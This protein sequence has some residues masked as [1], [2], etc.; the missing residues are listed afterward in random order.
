[1]C[2]IYNERGETVRHILS[3]FSM[4]AQTESKKRHE[5]V[6]TMVDRDYVANMVL[7][8][9]NTGINTKRRV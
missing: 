2:G 7:N 8:Q 1:M 6:A 3:E 4:L 9:L 5:K